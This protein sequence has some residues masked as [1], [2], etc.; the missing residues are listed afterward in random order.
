MYYYI[1]AFESSKFPSSLK[2]SKYYVCIKISNKNQKE[3]YRAV[4]I[5]PILSKMSEKI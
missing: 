3:N 4:N 2:T 1:K 5:Q